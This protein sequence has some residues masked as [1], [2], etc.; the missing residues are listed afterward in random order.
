MTRWR[1]RGGRSEQILTTSRDFLEE[2]L[3][4]GKNGTGTGQSDI[5]VGGVELIF[6]IVQE[7]GVDRGVRVVKLVRRKFF[8]DADPFRR[9]AGAIES[10]GVS[11]RDCGIVRRFFVGL[12]GKGAAGDGVVIEEEGETRG[13]GGESDFVGRTFVQPLRGQAKIRQIVCLPV[14]AE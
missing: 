10:E 11:D 9:S 13:I 2:L 3:F 6:V 8:Q 7:S 14:N 12:P 5:F 4:L 1:T